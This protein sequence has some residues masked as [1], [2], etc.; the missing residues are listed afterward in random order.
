MRECVGDESWIGLWIAEQKYVLHF[1]QW[2]WATGG[3]E[4]W[5]DRRSLIWFGTDSA[6]VALEPVEDLRD[7]SAGVAS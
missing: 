2:V 4:Q 7:E 3:G 1:H 5:A 6:E